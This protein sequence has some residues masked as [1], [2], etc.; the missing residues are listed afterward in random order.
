M[1]FEMSSAIYFNLDRSK[2]LLSGNWLT[3]YRTNNHQLTSQNANHCAS[4]NRPPK[5]VKSKTNK[6]NMVAKNQSMM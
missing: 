4:A 6:I 3:M 1:Y 5:S 2:I